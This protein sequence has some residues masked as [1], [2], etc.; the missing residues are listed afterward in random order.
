MSGPV[1]EGQLPLPMFLD[2]GATF[3]GIFTGPNSLA[4]QALH[5]AALT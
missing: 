2:Q 1:L 3:E 4:V 5:E